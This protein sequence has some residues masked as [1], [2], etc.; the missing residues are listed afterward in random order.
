MSVLVHQTLHTQT[1]IVHAYGT[2]VFSQLTCSTDTIVMDMAH[3]YFAFLCIF[4]VS[5]VLFHTEIVLDINSIG[6][7][8]I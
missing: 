8:R 4:Q 2:F 5:M 3:K 6:K 1:L 7:R